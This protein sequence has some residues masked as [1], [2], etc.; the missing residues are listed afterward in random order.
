[1]AVIQYASDEQVAVN[2]ATREEWRAVRVKFCTGKEETRTFTYKCHF[3]PATGV[4]GIVRTMGALRVVEVVES[5]VPTDE[6]CLVCHQW[7][8]PVSA[9]TTQFI[10]QTFDADEAALQKLKDHAHDLQASKQLKEVLER[11]I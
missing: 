10:S 9:V 4:L 5:R 11:V 1:M 2:H 6:D 8:F 3:K 7:L